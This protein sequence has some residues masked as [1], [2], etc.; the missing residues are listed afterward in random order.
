MRL[1]LALASCI[2]LLAP[3]LAVAPG[4]PAAT[5]VAVDPAAQTAPVTLSAGAQSTCEVRADSTAWC[6][7]RNDYGQLGDGTQTAR[8]APTQVVGIGF[9][10]EPATILNDEPLLGTGLAAAVRE[11]LGS[12]GFTF[13]DVDFRI[14]DST[15][16]AFGFR[17][18]TLLLARL[19]RQP[20]PAMP[21]WHPAEFI[22]SVGAASGVVHVALAVEAL[23]LGF[24][25]GV[26][27]VVCST[28]DFGERS[29]VALLGAAV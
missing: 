6:W 24:A 2:G 25:P 28:D 10:R 7:G 22:G 3:V 11:A 27:G 16:E 1:K 20:R 26:R 15:G 12:A 17:E 8:P 29:A 9:G 18:Q 19:L 13:Q 14:A 4:A 5:T 23:R 21:L